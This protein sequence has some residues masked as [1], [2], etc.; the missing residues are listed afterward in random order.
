[1]YA[2]PGG[3]SADVGTLGDMPAAVAEVKRLPAQGVS[4]AV[5]FLKT[6]RALL[7]INS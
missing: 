6:L 3:F 2:Q 4:L 7:P 5:V 1:V